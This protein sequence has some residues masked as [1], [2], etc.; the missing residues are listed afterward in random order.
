MKWRKRRARVNSISGGGLGFTADLMSDID[1]HEIDLEQE[2]LIEETTSASQ[3]TFHRVTELMERKFGVTR[4][5]PR[6]NRHLRQSNPNGISKRQ[7]LKKNVKFKALPRNQEA[8]RKSSSIDFRTLI[9]I[10]RLA[11]EK[12]TDWTQDTTFSEVSNAS[13]NASVIH[14]KPGCLGF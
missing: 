8:S 13:T 3:Q 6:S 7:A 4:K 9:K 11:R 1:E 12:N 5:L 2:R 14:Q 10:N